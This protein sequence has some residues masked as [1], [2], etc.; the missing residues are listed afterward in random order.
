MYES[1]DLRNKRIKYVPTTI[2]GREPKKPRDY[3]PALLILL[4]NDD[5]VI[6]ILFVEQ[7][8]LTLD[9][10]WFESKLNLLSKKGSNKE[11]NVRRHFFY[12]YYLCR[13]EVSY[14]KH[15]HKIKR[16]KL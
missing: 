9:I 16:S 11:N 3:R 2:F 12:E 10:N 6:G 15:I 14:S 7:N 4:A 1:G 8:I 13:K 5:H